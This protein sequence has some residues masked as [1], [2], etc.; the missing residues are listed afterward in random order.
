MWKPFEN[1]DSDRRPQGLGWFLLCATCTITSTVY[2][3]LPALMWTLWGVKGTT[4]A[5]IW[6]CGSLL[7]VTMHMHHEFR[8]FV[9]TNAPNYIFFIGLPLASFIS[10]AAPGRD[11]SLMLLFASLMY[12]SHMVVVFREYRVAST[13][14]LV[15]K[16][17]ARQRQASAEQANDAKSTFLANMSHEIRTPMN[18][19]LGMAAALEKSGVA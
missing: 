10:G 11:A 14:M 2:S 8:T 16:E 9:S 13:D 1:P 4:F 3:V 5:M 18:G 15:A 12:V 17:R 6:L 7:H 19:I